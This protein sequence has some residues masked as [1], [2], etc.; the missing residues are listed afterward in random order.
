P[1]SHWPALWLSWRAERD[2]CDMSA[3]AEFQR[4]HPDSFFLDAN[5]LDSLAHYL[6]DHEW[7]KPEEWV[8]SAARAGEGNMNCTL[9]ITT[10]HRSFIM[11]Q[12]RPWVEKYPQIA[13][14]W[15]RAVVEAQFYATIQSNAA[16][17]AYIPQLIRFDPGARLLMLEDCG[18]SP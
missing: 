6:Q 10:S 18:D 13:A 7:I 2:V 14:P 15:D 11:K 16:I 12:A 8:L 9:R 3:R 1:R 5:D 4:S 17:G